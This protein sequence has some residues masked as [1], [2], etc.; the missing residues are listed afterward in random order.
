MNKFITGFFMAWG[1]FLALPCPYKKWD[2]KL[3]YVMLAMFPSVGFVAGIIWFT[4][5][6]MLRV[7]KTPGELNAFVLVFYIFYICGFMHLDGFMDCNDAILS[8]KPMEIKRKILKESTV[9]AFAVVTCIFLM[10]AWYAVATCYM[11]VVESYR[12]LFTMV[13]LPVA[14][15]V[16]STFW[17]T[18]YA[19]MESSQYLEDYKEKNKGKYGTVAALQFVVYAG[20]VSIVSGY[21]LSVIISSAVQ[22]AVS[23]VACLH[24]RKQLGAMNG[25]VA[26]YA[27]C[28]SEL[29]GIVT[30]FL[31]Q[32]YI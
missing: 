13:M 3:K 19:P 8:R 21:L 15:R 18:M 10:M 14:S 30:L 1:N 23:Y 20:F 26:G 29:A 12:Q 24:G 25:D 17:V 22:V 27:L 32:F 7:V 5:M 11:G 6:S 4:L 31:T 16:C 2:N 28:F 9:G